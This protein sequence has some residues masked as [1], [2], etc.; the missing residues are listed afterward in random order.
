MAKKPVSLETVASPAPT[1]TADALKA[2]LAEAVAEAKAQAK[3]EF[4]AEMAAEQ[5]KLSMPIP[6]IS[7]GCTDLISPG[8][9][10]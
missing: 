10:R 7:P 2:L 9:P 8:I 1:L 4:M 6:M 5:P 3:A